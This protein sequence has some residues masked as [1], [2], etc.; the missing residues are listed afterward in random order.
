MES[1]AGKP[2]RLSAKSFFLTF[3]QCS[4]SK[5][6]IKSG[7]QALFPSGFRI[8]RELHQDGSPHI[9]VL[10]FFPKRKEIKN[11]RAFDIGGFHCNIQATKNPKQ[12]LQYL[13][14]GNQ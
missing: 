8:A 5:E 11:A 14:K 12:A 13:L 10:L 3:P 1:A 2:F 9:H 6:H 4:L 7:L